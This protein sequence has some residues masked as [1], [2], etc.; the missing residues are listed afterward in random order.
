MGVLDV[1]FRGSQETAKGCRHRKSNAL[2][3]L[4]IGRG[5]R[6]KSHRSSLANEDSNTNHD[7]DVRMH[8]IQWLSYVAT[9]HQRT[10]P[11]YCSRGVGLDRKRVLDVD[12][13]R[14]V[15]C[16]SLKKHPES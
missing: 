12:M 9:E 14:P 15:L 11:V 6:A 3:C 5:S 2:T 8:Q 10:R 16:D 13:T 7:M 1:E 4:S